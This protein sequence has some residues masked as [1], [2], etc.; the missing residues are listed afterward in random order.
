MSSGAFRD[1]SAAVE[2]AAVLEDEN[3]ALNEEVVTLRAEVLKLRAELEEARQGPE[4]ADAYAK[5]VHEERDELLREVKDLRESLGVVAPGKGGPSVISRLKTQLTAEREKARFETG[6]R[7]TLIVALTAERDAAHRELAAQAS[8]ELAHLPPGGAINRDAY[9]QRIQEERDELLREVRILRDTVA[10]R[11]G[12]SG[13]TSLLTR[14]G[15]L[16]GPP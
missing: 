12:V 4:N 6:E 8:D 3:R 16:F 13:S 10:G 5:R 2:R 14:L 7:T 1:A 15:K 9:V 11:G